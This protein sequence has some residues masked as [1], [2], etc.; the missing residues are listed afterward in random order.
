MNVKVVPLPDTLE[1]SKIYVDSDYIYI[2]GNCTVHVFDK[3]TFKLK[4]SFGR[5]GEGPKEFK[6]NPDLVFLPGKLAAV[7]HQKTAFYTREGKYIKEMRGVPGEDTYPLGNRFLVRGEESIGKTLYYTF[8]IYNAK[9]EKEKKL[10]TSK[11][12]MQFNRKQFHL[13]SRYLECRV[14]GNRVFG[15]TGGGMDIDGFDENGK[16]IFSLHDKNIKKLKLPAERIK[17]IHQWMS[18]SPQFK[19]TYKMMKSWL[20]FP[21][22]YPVIESFRV[23]DDHLYIV[24]YKKDKN[25]NKEIFVYSLTG[26]F[27]RRVFLPV[28]EQ[29]PW[30]YYQY[31]I[32]DDTFYQLSENQDEENYEIQII[33]F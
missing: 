8:N 3:K 18:E 4:T 29:D 1:P 6:Y 11:R 30:L 15:V 31:A 20:K 9:L 24:T 13:F 21:D 7:T 28:V 5:R 12:Y 17:A 23:A 25:G 27:K 19:P 32:K 14:Y 26:K 10:W 33:R 22:Y 16:Q 2:T